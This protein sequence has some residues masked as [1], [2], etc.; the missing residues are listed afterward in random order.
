MAV[1]N[2]VRC[3]KF[4]DLESGRFWGV[5][6]KTVP[7]GTGK[8]RAWLNLAHHPLRFINFVPCSAA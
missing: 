1:Y 3:P 2:A 6:G 7:T 5:R 8:L 4:Q